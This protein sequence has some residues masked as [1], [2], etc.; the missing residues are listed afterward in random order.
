MKMAGGVTG[1]NPSRKI[2]A[3]NP[4]VDRRFVIDMKDYGGA[5]KLIS[6]T[7]NSTIT[8]NGN[9]AAAVGKKKNSTTISNARA[10]YNNTT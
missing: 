5:Q 6:T 10:Y 7:Q 9:V 4:N 2:A 1:A 3:N 8:I